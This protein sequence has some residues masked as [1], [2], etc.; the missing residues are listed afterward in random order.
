MDDFARAFT[1]N[2]SFING[3][4]ESFVGREKIKNRYFHMH[5]NSNFILKI[6]KISLRKVQNGV[7]E[8]LIKWQDENAGLSQGDTITDTRSGTF[9]QFFLKEGDEWLIVSSQNNF[10]SK[11]NLWTD[12]K[13]EGLISG[14][15]S[16]YYKNGAFINADI[17]ADFLESTFYKVK[18]EK[19][20][21]FGTTFAGTTFADSHFSDCELSKP[22]FADAV[23]KGT[24]SFQNIKGVN[25][26]EQFVTCKIADEQ[27]NNFHWITAQDAMKLDL[28][29]KT[30]MRTPISF[31]SIQ[32][33]KILKAN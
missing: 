19:S 32:I 24:T 29:F 5:E 22:N 3:F 11:D 2:A 20:K 16:N 17:T 31:T 14:S 4:G 30:W 9:T 27:S 33:W 8:A 6:K 15:H 13:K 10:V 1:E 23:L 28:H 21:F 12:F 7:I 26:K 25:F 18:F